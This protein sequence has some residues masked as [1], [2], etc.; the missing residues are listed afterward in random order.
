MSIRPSTLA[1]LLLAPASASAWYIS[2]LTGSNETP[3][4]VALD[5]AGNVHVAGIITYGCRN[6]GGAAVP[7]TD[8]YV[9]KYSPDGKR[10]LY[11]RVIGGSG[12]ESASGLAVDHQGNAY[13]TGGTGSTDFPTTPGAWRTASNPSG[14]SAFLVKLD[15]TGQRTLYSTYLTA[16]FV[17]PAL[18]VDSDGRAL[19]QSPKPQECRC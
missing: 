18:A 5:Q 2:A 16:G 14:A 11:H 8:A 10:L 13:V 9:S 3:V 6:L 12:Q 4:A 1:A 19:I 7:D 17:S 15:P